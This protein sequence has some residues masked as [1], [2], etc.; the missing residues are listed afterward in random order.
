ARQAI[1]TENHLGRAKC[2]LCGNCQRGCITRSYF[3]SLNATLPAAQQTGRLTLRPFS[4]VHSVIYDPKTRRAT[5][6]RVVDANTRKMF[7]VYAKIVFLNA[8]ALE[9]ARILLNSATEEFPTGL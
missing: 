5:G 4:V 1:L 9:S 8:S 6:V 7:D 2:H 3:S